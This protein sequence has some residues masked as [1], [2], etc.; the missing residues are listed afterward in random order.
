MCEFPAEGDNFETKGEIV[1]TWKMLA[2]LVTEPVRDEAWI[3]LQEISEEMDIPPLPL[4]PDSRSK[5][6]TEFIARFTARLREIPKGF[7]R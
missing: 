7:W 5:A 6:C 3:V 2:F 4:A 1:E